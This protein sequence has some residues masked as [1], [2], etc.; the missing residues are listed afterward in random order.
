M[1][2]VVWTIEATER[3]LRETMDFRRRRKLQ[4]PT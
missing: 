3:W 1:S 4:P 2:E